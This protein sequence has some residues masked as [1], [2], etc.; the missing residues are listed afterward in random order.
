MVEPTY[1]KNKQPKEVR[2]R[3]FI[4][5]TDEERKL[6]RDNSS[7]I[8]FSKLLSPP[9]QD[10]LKLGEIAGNIRS[11]YPNFKYDR[12]PRAEHQVRRGAFTPPPR[13]SLWSYLLDR[14]CAANPNCNFQTGHH[15]HWHHY[16]S[17]SD[18]SCRQPNGRVQ[19]QGRRCAISLTERRPTQGES[20][21]SPDLSGC[22]QG[23]SR[24][25]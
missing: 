8:S 13:N 4:A 7:I 20:T 12:R 22:N 23:R 3:T 19:P 17:L 11:Y 2:V 1:F 6:D 16:I 18:R 14:R 25:S 9:L 10:L 15:Y 21:E 24:R 5:P